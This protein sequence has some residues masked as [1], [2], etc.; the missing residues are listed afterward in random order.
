MSEIKLV[1]SSYSSLLISEFFLLSSP[2]DI[3]HI[4]RITLDTDV[5]SSL[6]LLAY[7]CYL[8]NL[9][10]H[11]SSI[12]SSLLQQTSYMMSSHKKN[13]GLLDCEVVLIAQQQVISTLET[14]FLSCQNLG[15]LSVI[16][17]CQK[18]SK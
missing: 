6:S 14:E 3:D 4:D 7:S 5:L 16:F 1:I 18:H 12:R 10:L 11:L 8:F 9:Y 15:Q 17:V 2:V 13:V